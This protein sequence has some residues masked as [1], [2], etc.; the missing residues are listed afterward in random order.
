MA[1]LIYRNKPLHLTGLMYS[2]LGSDQSGLL[3]PQRATIVL[4][5]HFYGYFSR[6]NLKFLVQLPAAVTFCT[7]KNH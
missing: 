3:P 2:K 5:H 4:H 7:G 1:P 6:N